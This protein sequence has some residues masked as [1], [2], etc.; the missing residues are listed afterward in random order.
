VKGLEFSERFGIG[1]GIWMRSF[2]VLERMVRFESGN[3]LYEIMLNFRS[4]KL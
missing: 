4:V 2:G 1:I 3:E